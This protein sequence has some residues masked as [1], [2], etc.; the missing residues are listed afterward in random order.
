MALCSDEPT[1]KIYDLRAD[2]ICQEIPRPHQDSLSY[3]SGLVF[4][5]TECIRSIRWSPCGT[6]LATAAEEVIVT[7]VRSLGQVYQSDQDP[8]GTPNYR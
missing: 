1:L 8:S 4:G 3:V 6:L 5:K 7:D 2:K